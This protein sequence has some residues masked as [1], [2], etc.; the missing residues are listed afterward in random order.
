MLDVIVIGGG[1]VGSR[2]ASQLAGKG[3]RVGLLEK[4]SGIGQKSCCTGIVSRECVAAYEIPD[5]VIYRKVNSARIY[6]PG[7]ETLRVYRSEVQAC[8]LKRAEFDRLMSAR[9]KRAGVEYHLSTGVS[10]IC[11][12][13]DRV[14]VEAE[15][16]AKKVRFES[17]AVV[18]ACGFNPV[19]VKQ[20]G[21]G[22]YKY[23]VN[24][25]QIEIPVQGLEEI[26]VYLDQKIAPGFFGWIVPTDQG[27]CLAGL[28]TRRSPGV[29][30]NT[31]L[32]ALEKR[33][34]IV[35]DK[36][37]T[38]IG[39]IPLKP[40]GRTY[41][42]R[43]L[44][45][46]DAAGQVKPTTGGGIYFGLLCADMAAKTLDSALRHGDLSAHNLAGYERSWQNKLESE[47]RAEYLARRIY[48]CLNDRQ[49]EALFTRLKE[50][51]MVDSILQQEDLSFDWHGKLLKQALKTSATARLKRL[52][53]LPATLLK[54]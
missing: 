4:R 37:K 3:Y 54:G 11:F 50:S 7:G 22:S 44:I 29:Y 34:A 23:S 27:H 30:L 8:I 13:P 46:G 35:R 53:S 20:L 15:R 28:L 17:R 5:E 6:S 25:A 49:I 10:R 45:V 36:E 33:L 9:A 18:A 42:E 40:L 43:F 51:G 32:A 31:W 16:E 52:L 26:E 19:L 14:T 41:G 1:P 21:V 38:R 12:D 24:G 39:S 48:E 47:L 2:T